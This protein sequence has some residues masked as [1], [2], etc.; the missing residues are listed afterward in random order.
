M[1]T[2]TIK[3]NIRYGINCYGKKPLIT[4][5]ER[6]NMKNM[7]EFPLTNKEIAFNESVDYW[8]MQ[9]PKLE[10]APF[11]HNNWSVV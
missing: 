5:Q 7:P 4:P 2:I 6:Y 1:G 10:V 9:L 8:R 3:Q 11:S